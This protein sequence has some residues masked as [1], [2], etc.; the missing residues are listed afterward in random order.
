M[1]FETTSDKPM[2]MASTCTETISTTAANALLKANE[3]N[4]NSL[5]KMM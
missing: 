1:I 2:L 5:E 4:K 3:A